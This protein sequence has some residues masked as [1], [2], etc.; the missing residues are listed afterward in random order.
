MMTHMYDALL[1]VNSINTSC[2]R[3]V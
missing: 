1:N 3:D 2:D